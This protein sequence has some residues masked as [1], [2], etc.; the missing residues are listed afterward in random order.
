MR[1]FIGEDKLGEPTR[2][3]A[4]DEFVFANRWTA[5]R[6]FLRLVQEQEF[7]LDA[8]TAVVLDLDKTA[9]GARGRNDK[10]IDQARVDAALDIARS[11]L[12]ESFRME[13]FR[14][15]YDELHKSVYHFITTDN[16]DYLVYISLMAS[17]GVYDG[18][19]LLADLKSKRLNTFEEF[20]TVCESRLQDFPA[21]QPL[22]AEVAGNVRRGDPTPFKSFRYREY[23]CTIAR[24]DRLPDDT[25]RAQL[26]ADEITITGEV[27]D[28]ALELRDRGALLFGLSDKPDEASLPRPDVA[29]R[30]YVPLHHV[31]MKVIGPNDG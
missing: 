7:A 1:T 8:A 18:D 12:G 17:A 28:A 19:T 11:T 23:E 3:E 24:M 10:P 26:L 4:Q 20:V 13:T 30:G 27:A 16:Q 2:L 31:T 22:H 21:L 5:L 14:P 9:I 6:D 15:I 29:R 25:P